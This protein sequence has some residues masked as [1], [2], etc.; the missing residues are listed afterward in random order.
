MATVEVYADVVCP[1]AYAGLSRLLARRH[2]LGRD[3]VR[4]RIRA[5][6]LELVNGEPVDGHHIGEEVLEIKRQV[7]PDL[8]TKFE[9]SHFPDTSLPALALTAAAYDVSDAV[10][11]SVAMEVRQLLFERGENVADTGVL[12]DLARRN[13]LPDFD[14]IGVVREEWVTG[15]SRGVVGSPHFFVD[16]QSLFCPVL[17]IQHVDGHLEVKVD[18]PAYYA[19][20]ARCFD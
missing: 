9:E 7:A 10:G 15:R 4:F 12:T 14:D 5:W 8:F 2:E 11:E 3:D 16:G 17:D 13:G 20:V 19:F 1:F 6:P 18:E